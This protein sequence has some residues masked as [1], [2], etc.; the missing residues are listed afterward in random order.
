M[1]KLIIIYKQNYLMAVTNTVKLLMIKST[2][3]NM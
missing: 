2:Y 3:I 1:I